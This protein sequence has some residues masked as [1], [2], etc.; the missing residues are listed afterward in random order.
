MCILAQLR[1]LRAMKERKLVH[2]GRSPPWPTKTLPL[3]RVPRFF[4][5]VPLQISMNSIETLQPIRRDVTKCVGIDRGV[6]FCKDPRNEGKN[7]V[8]VYGKN[9]GIFLVESIPV[10]HMIFCNH[11][12]FPNTK[13]QK[14]TCTNEAV[15]SI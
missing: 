1:L 13:Q 8:N 14:N 6:C 12:S 7:F 9:L 5:L 10:S 2:A 3:K 4:G 11:F 15:R